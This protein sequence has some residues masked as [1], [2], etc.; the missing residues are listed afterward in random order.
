MALNPGD[1]PEI[2][3]LQMKLGLYVNT[4]EHYQCL[5]ITL[6]LIF[7]KTGSLT[8]PLKPFHSFS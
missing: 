3:N 8:G 7:D 4:M 2:A 5:A 1:W 6:I